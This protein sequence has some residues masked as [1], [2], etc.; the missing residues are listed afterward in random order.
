MTTSKQTAET[1][2][3]IMGEGKDAGHRQPACGF[4]EPQ[5]SVMTALPLLKEGKEAACVYEYS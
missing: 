3:H 1:H 5:M 4:A 2:T